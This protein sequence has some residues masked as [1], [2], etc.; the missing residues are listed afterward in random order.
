MKGIDFSILN[1]K[2]TIQLNDPQIECFFSF[3]NHERVKR[4]ED[5]ITFMTLHAL[6]VLLLEP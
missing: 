2:E 1:H 3:S 6:M 4:Y 5:Q